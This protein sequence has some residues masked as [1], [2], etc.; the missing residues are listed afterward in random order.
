[1]ERT[2]EAKSIPDIKAVKGSD[3][4]GIHIGVSLKKGD[5]S[6]KKGETEHTIFVE[7]EDVFVWVCPNCETEN[8][9]SD[10]QCTVCHNI[11]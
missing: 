8:Q 6:S 1:M 7:N 4:K 11:R 10:Y 3:S 5:I 9:H 2:E